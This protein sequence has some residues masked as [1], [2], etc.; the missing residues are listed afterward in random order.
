[1]LVGRYRIL[2]ELGRGGMATVYDA[3]RADGAFEQRVAIK[4]LRRGLDTDDIVERFLAERQILS[5]LEHANIARLIDGGATSDGRPYLVMERVSGEPITEWANRRG[6]SVRERLRLFCQVA[7]AVQVAHQRLIIHR[8]L[9]PSNILVDESGTVKL[10]DFGIAKLLDPAGAPGGDVL[11]RTGMRPL[12]PAPS[13]CAASGSP[14][15][16]ISINSARSSSSS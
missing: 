6:L 7:E 2:G 4:L 5:G 3:E 15:P 11:T 1:D 13:R 14:P 10:L 12:T 16:Q 8:D 9:K